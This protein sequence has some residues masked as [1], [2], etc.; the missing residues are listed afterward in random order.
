[1]ENKDVCFRVIENKEKDRKHDTD[2]DL[3]I[4]EVMV[5]VFINESKLE[6]KKYKILKSKLQEWGIE[7]QKHV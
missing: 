6:G 4:Q 5:V 7:F 2:T 1:M 3:F